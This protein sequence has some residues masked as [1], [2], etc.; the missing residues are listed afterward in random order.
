MLQAS[1][2]EWDLH[3]VYHYES[4]DKFDWQEGLA[5]TDIPNPEGSERPSLSAR[6]VGG[7]LPTTFHQLKI[8]KCPNL[9]ILPEGMMHTSN[10]S[11]H[12][13]EIFNCSSISSFP[14]G[15]LPKALK[16]L[17]VWNCFN[18]ESLPDIRTKTMLL[19]SIRVGNYTENLKFLPEWMQNL[20]SLQELQ[21]SNCPSI[22]S[23]QEGGLP[24]SLVSLDIK[25]WKNLMPMSE[26]GLHRLASLRRLT[27]H[28]ISSNLSCFPEWLLPSTLETLNIVQ[29]SN[30]ESLS[31]WLQNFTS[32]ENLKVKDCRNLLSLPKEGVPPM[33]SYLEISGCHLLEQNCDWSKI[34]HIPCIVISYMSPEYVMGGVFSEKSDVYSVGVLKLNIAIYDHEK[35]SDLLSYDNGADWTSTSS[36]VL[37]LSSEMDLPRPKQPTFVFHRWLDSDSINVLQSWWQKGDN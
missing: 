1:R 28:G 11:L 24:T 3:R 19:E 32:L 16:T 33:L 31:P 27:I 6:D 23:F 35:H 26:W 29:L 5:V 18:L 22:T 21:L 34:D 12:V 15:Q 2:I 30:L 17:T 37:M 20:T 4:Y 8:E 7:L 13:L 14:E 10:T 36:V 9:E 25:D